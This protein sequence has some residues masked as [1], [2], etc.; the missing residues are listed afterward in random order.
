MNTKL[1]KEMS[2]YSGRVKQPITHIFLPL[3]IPGPTDDAEDGAERESLL[4]NPVSR[5]NSSIYGSQDSSR[6]MIYDSTSAIEH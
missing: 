3:L 1:C 2:L 5:T 4:R 6:G